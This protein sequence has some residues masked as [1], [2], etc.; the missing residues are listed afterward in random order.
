MKAVLRG[1]N[2]RG[3]VKEGSD[4]RYPTA[5]CTKRRPIAPGRE[6]PW[7]DGLLSWCCATCCSGSG[8][9]RRRLDHLLPGFGQEDKAALS[10]RLQGLAKFQEAALRHAFSLPSLQRLVY[11][12]CSVHREEN[13]DVVAAVLPLA[14][15]LGFHLVDPFPSWP[16]RGLPVLAGSELLVRVDEEKDGTDGFFIAVFERLSCEPRAPSEEADCGRVRAREER[17]RRDTP[18]GGEKIKG[19][20]GCVGLGIDGRV[21]K[22]GRAGSKKKRKQLKRSL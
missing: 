16:R 22:L 5:G 11:S 3:E 1:K 21:E 17:A 4:I 19:A 9:K 10:Q 12:T 14:E 8:T 20:E 18:G 7:A 2:T 13:E 15:E 6:E